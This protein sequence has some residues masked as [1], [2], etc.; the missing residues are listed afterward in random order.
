MMAVEGIEKNQLL[1][2]DKRGLLDE[3]RSFF[4]LRLKTLLQEKGIRYDVIDA[5]LAG[6]IS[7]VSTVFAKAELLMN[8]QTDPT[9]KPA[10]E[11]LSRVTNIA[12]HQ[13]QQATLD[14]ALFE[15]EQE[16]RLYSIYGQVK[17]EVPNALAKGEVDEAFQMLSGLA[18]A[19]DQY[20]DHIMVMTEDETMKTNRLAQMGALAELIHSFA[21]FQKLV[22]SSN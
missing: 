4:R 22:F 3:L 9:F 12:V 13:D 20:F 6:D 17:E 1:K 15:K 19:I 5:V 14:P 10:V 8:K 21:D 11:A 2:Q 18:P 16:E 7:V